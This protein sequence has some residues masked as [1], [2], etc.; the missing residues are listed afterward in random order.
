MA[1]SQQRLHNPVQRLPAA[2]RT[3]D[4][5][6]LPLVPLTTSRAAHITRLY[7]LLLHLVA[8]PPSPRTSSQAVR[9]WRAL[10]G[11]REV[12]LAVL[13]RLGAAVIDRTRGEG[14]EQDDD[15]NDEEKR[16]RA[17]RRAEWL[18][19]CQEGRHDKVDK[20]SEYCLALVGAGRAEFALDELDAYLDN[21]PYHD[22]IA[23]NTLYGL[24]AL[25]VAQPSPSTAPTPRRARSSSSSSE[26]DG[27]PRS[28]G[29]AAKR[30]RLAGGGAAGDDVSSDAEY[31]PLLRAM[32]LN[33]PLLFSKATER[34]KRAAHLEERALREAER[35]DQA[36]KVTGEAA[37]WLSM[38]RRHV[39]KTSSSREASPA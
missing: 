5:I 14:A 19:S 32:A 35:G 31:A 16:D 1:F 39:E 20:F 36:E 12:P 38:I 30:P 2:P 21:Q 27:G 4:Y 9:A 18:K 34:F 13:W 6:P 37:R 25:L 24:L 8:L 26:S 23:L 29:R 22:S 11:C 3:R 33:S 28:G 17:A 10:A 15:E 7:N